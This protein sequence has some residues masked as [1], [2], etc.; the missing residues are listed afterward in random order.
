MFCVHNC[1][2]CTCSVN[3]HCYL[4]DPK[5]LS[6]Y[7]SFHLSE[8]PFKRWHLDLISFVADT[9]WALSYL[10]DGT[11]DKIQ[12]V[13]DTG[14][15]P[16]LVALLAS[17]EVTVLTP[18]L[19]AVGNIVTGNDIQVCSLS[20]VGTPYL[21]NARQPLQS[22]NFESMSTPPPFLPLC[23]FLCG[24][25]GVF[26]FVHIIICWCVFTVLEQ[27]DSITPYLRPQLFV[28][29]AILYSNC[30]TCLLKSSCW[31]SNCQL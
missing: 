27:T 17:T 22:M 3:K 15:V 18:A 1:F 29:Y 8:H 28:N 31:I 2:N 9:C 14:V 16:R 25:G 12:A 13:I 4:L 20:L 30:R 26:H 19:R 5:G 24:S 6:C 10:T 11:N 7:N 23:I 21:H